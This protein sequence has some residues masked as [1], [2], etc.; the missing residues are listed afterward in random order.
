MREDE[1][2]LRAYPYEAYLEQKYDPETNFTFLA[3]DRAAYDRNVTADQIQDKT[4]RTVILENEFLALTF[5]PELGGRLYQVHYKPTGQTLFYNNRVLKPS[6]WGPPEQGGWLAVGGME[7]A[8]PVSEHGYEWG[9]PWDYVIDQTAGGATITL[10][11]SQ[12]SDRVRA[13][14]RVTLPAHAAY[15]IVEPR[16]ENPTDQPARVQFWTNAQL[17]L[18]A[19]KNTSPNTEFYLPTDRVFVHSTGSGFIPAENIPPEDAS[20][21]APPITFSNVG[22]RD[23]RRYANWDDYLG[24]FAAEPNLRQNFVGAYNHDA[25]LGIVRVFPPNH[26]PGVKLFGF[27]PNF[28]CR[29]A[30]TDDDSD[31]IELWGGLPR[32]FFA[33][34]D[35]VLAPGEARE[36]QETWMPFAKTDGLSAASRDAVLRLQVTNGTARLG[37]Y[38]AVPRETVLVLL[39]DGRELKR[40][41]LALSPKQPFTASVSVTDDA[42]LQLRLLDAAGDLILDCSSGSRQWLPLLSPADC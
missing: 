35:I 22:G 26:A 20:S 8:L 25:Q 31:Y 2:T 14:I 39:Q 10:I 1:L 38:S 5:I 34:D 27:G 24:V 30:F 40:W 4:L 32:T 36:W 41:S 17:A 6:P 9:V 33:D 21:P 23:L 42:K 3:L 13:R 16:L 37:A 18:G 19:D 15:L 29:D 12:A 7:W 11:D 28:C